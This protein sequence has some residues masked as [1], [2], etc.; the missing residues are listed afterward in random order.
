MEH[1]LVKR[2]VPRVVFWSMTKRTVVVICLTSVLTSCTVSTPIRTVDMNNGS[3]VSTGADRRIITNQS[4]PRNSRPGQVTPN[5]IVCAEPSPDISEL[6][7]NSLSAALK[8]PDKGELSV[9]SQTAS[10]VIQLAERTTTISLLRDQ[11]YRACE[12]YSNGAIS[13]TTYSLIM[14]KNNDAM[15]TLMLG[16]NAAGAF[17]RSGASAGSKASGT[18]ASKLEGS[19][20]SFQQILAGQTEAEKA[21]QQALTNHAAA[22]ELSNAKAEI[23]ST[24][25]AANPPAATDPQKEE[26]KKAKEDLD[27]AASELNAAKTLRD[28]M[29]ENVLSASEITLEAS[30]EFTEI[31]GVGGL[32]VNPSKDIAL[33]LEQIQSNFLHRDFFDDFLATCMVEMG[34]NERP[35][36]DIYSGI[37]NQK[38]PLAYLRERL[39]LIEKSTSITDPFSIIR[40]ARANKVYEDY[41]SFL[42]DKRQTYLSFLCYEQVGKLLPLSL[43]NSFNLKISDNALKA[44]EIGLESISITEKALSHCAKLE[45]AERIQCLNTIAKV[46][47]SAASSLPLL[48]A[49][50]ATYL[51]KDRIEEL[52]KQVL[53]FREHF[54]HINSNNLPLIE[55][56]S[57]VE[58]EDKEIKELKATAGTE[59]ELLVKRINQFMEAPS[60]KKVQD[61]D[62]YPSSLFDATRSSAK[63]LLKANDLQEEW[64]KLNGDI[65]EQLLQ[66]DDIPRLSVLRGQLAYNQIQAKVIHDKAKYHLDKIEGLVRG[67]EPLD[68]DIDTF[69]ENFKEVLQKTENTEV[70][71]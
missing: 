32:S 41:R 18:A 70:A 71:L 20:N 4:L 66:N 57:D 42:Q 3:S 64:K 22:E 51:P 62:N 45:G 10:A 30:S 2:L 48:K 29:A 35:W 21:Y 37:S 38:D 19:M 33:A 68:T 61:A 65:S 6:V 28:K 14:S 39:D 55:V 9:S 53:K 26:A 69:L 5:R 54:A 52:Q 43:T 17:G 36:H 8:V 67:I 59:I 23:V 58:G 44:K 11:M 25:D 15:V 7:S 49:A 50:K 1:R 16:E 47:D 31:N 60:L 13:G 34:H 27:L 40:R 63:V 12:A 46:A 56:E 24:A